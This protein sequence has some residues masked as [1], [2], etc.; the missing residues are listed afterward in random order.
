[1]I[2]I[3][4]S[5]SNHMCCAVPATEEHVAL[6]VDCGEMEDDATGVDIAIIIISIYNLELRHI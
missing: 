4:E 1:M 6:V 5:I 3:S 2:V